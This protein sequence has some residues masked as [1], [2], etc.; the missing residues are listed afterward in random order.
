MVGSWPPKKSQ[1]D[2]HNSSNGS[3]NNS[4]N[5]HS[6]TTSFASPRKFSSHTAKSSTA[7]KELGADKVYQSF[8]H[9]PRF[10]LFEDKAEIQY[11][12]DDATAAAAY[13]DRSFIKQKPK[14]SKPHTSGYDFDALLKHVNVDD[15][16]RSGK[17]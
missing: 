6:S 10:Q 9:V 1:E 11:L 3:F 16:R 15:Y 4:F 13:G 8:D 2:S 7:R 17:K 5:N 14:I 12:D